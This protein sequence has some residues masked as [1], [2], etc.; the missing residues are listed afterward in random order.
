MTFFAG[1]RYERIGEVELE[2]AHGRLVRCKRTRF[3]PDTP[4][5]LTHVVTD[6]DRIDLLAHRYLG[7]PERFWRICDANPAPWPPDL[8]AHAGRTIQIPGASDG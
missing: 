4:G 2:D 8:L 1:S 7:D 6:H 5:R 3:V